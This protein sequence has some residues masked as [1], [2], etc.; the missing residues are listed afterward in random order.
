MS[1]TKILGAEIVKDDHIRLLVASATT[2]AGAVQEYVIE[3][4]RKENVHM[5]PSKDFLDAYSMFAP[6]LMFK[7]GFF[8]IDSFKEE[9]FTNH[10]YRNDSRFMNI[11]VTS[12][13]FA[14]KDM[15]TIIIAGEITNDNDETTKLV[16]PPI[17]LSD[18]FVSEYALV[19][20]LRK[21]VENWMKEVKNFDAGKYAEEYQ[22]KM[23]LK[24]AS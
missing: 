7:I 1:K 24:V 9:F 11:S 17:K 12:V 2:K 10:E 19:A 20:I 22:L 16:S 18:E 14:N 23:D 3:K 6:H 4:D 5:K 13:K 8:E 15:D 21:N